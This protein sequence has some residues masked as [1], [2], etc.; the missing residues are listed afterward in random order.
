MQITP[1]PRVWKIWKVIKVTRKT[2]EI[3]QSTVALLRL[4]PCRGNILPSFFSTQKLL[5]SIPLYISPFFTDYFEFVKGDKNIYKD[6]RNESISNNIYL[7][8]IVHLK[9]VEVI[10]KNHLHKLRW[11][12]VFE[13]DHDSK[14]ST[15]STFR[16][17]YTTSWPRQTD[18]SRNKL[19]SFSTLTW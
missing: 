15:F 19:L 16:I 10:Y 11:N 18:M 1:N 3:T 17:F 8:C 13:D 12:R 6:L 5:T 4:Y 9:R 2:A 14:S 7:K